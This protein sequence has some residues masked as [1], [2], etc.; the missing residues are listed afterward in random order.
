MFFSVPVVGIGMTPDMLQAIIEDEEH[1]EFERYKKYA[2]ELHHHNGT[3]VEVRHLLRRGFAVDEIVDVSNE[4]NANLIVM[5]TKG[6]SG[7][8]EII[9]GSNTSNVIGRTSRPVLA[10]P[11]NAK[12]KGIKKIAYAMQF[13]PD[14]TEY[15][16][17]VVKFAQLFDAE[18]HCIHVSFM[19]ELWDEAQLGV[20]KKAYEEEH[21]GSNVFFEILHDTDTEA[22]INEYIEENDID[23]LAVLTHKR[24]FFDSLFHRSFSKKMSFHTDIPL[25]VFST[26]S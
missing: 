1:I 23:V 19:E 6:S 4:I 10:I 3:S 15:I 18:V 24:K 25:L 22:A 14:E 11:E 8:A 12:F 9:I 16:D 5:G 20:L 2:E 13:N 17:K 21:A 26:T 7:L